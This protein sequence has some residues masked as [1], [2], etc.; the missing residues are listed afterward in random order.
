MAKPKHYRVVLRDA[1]GGQVKFV[2]AIIESTDSLSELTKHS[3]IASV[4]EEA[5]K[6]ADLIS[7]GL[8]KAFPT[9]VIA[10]IENNRVE[11]VE[12]DTR[13]VAEL[14]AELD[15]L[16]IEYPKNVKRDELIELLK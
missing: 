6:D 2:E 14:K 16:G 13:T 12:E 9:D 8:A 11:E 4:I 15:T 3:H 7:D 1:T 5:Y 10:D